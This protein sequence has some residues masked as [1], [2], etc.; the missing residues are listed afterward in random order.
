MYVGVKDRREV[1]TKYRL[2]NHQITGIIIR[3]TRVKIEEKQF[4]K[5]IVAGFLG[6][7]GLTCHTFLFSPSLQTQ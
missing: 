5:W 3:T 4:V 1:I 6:A 2:N 7:A